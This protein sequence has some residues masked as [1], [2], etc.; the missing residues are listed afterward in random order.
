MLWSSMF[1]HHRRKIKLED[2]QSNVVVITTGYAPRACLNLIANSTLL[3]RLCDSKA[4]IH[5]SSSMICYKPICSLW[6]RAYACA[7]ST[8]SLNKTGST[9]HAPFRSYFN[10]DQYCVCITIF[11]IQLSDVHQFK[12]KLFYIG[13]RIC[14]CSMFYI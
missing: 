1:R 14:T 4:H 2:M 7:F 10:F 3:L 6:A 9:L 13:L 12:Y 8:C 5:D 11:S